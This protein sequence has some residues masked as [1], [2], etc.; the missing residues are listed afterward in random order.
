MSEGTD[1]DDTG[2]ARPRMPPGQAVR[3]EHK[4]LHYGPVPAFRPQ[5]WDLRVTGATEDLGS[6]RWTWEEFARL[7]RTDSV[8]DFHCVMRFSVPGVPWRGVLATDLVAAAP[9]APEATHVMAWGEYGYGANL[10]M[11]DFLAEG[12]L[13]ATHRDGEPLAPDHGAPLRLVVPHLYGWKS[14]KWLRAVEYMTA[15]RRG[16]W[17]ERGYHN[18]GDPWR[19]QRFSHQE[20]ERGPGRAPRR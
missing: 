20:E 18:R 8:S 2:G 10:R 19:E 3:Q 12:V 16:F 6:Y 13:L 17:E 15:D 11:D 4:P 1:E 5:R 7:P 9:P 14:V